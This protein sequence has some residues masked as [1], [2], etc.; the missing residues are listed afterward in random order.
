MPYDDIYNPDD[1][2]NPY[3]EATLSITNLYSDKEVMLIN[4]FAFPFSFSS[5][6]RTIYQ[7]MVNECFLNPEK[8]VKWIPSVRRCWIQWMDGSKVAAINRMTPEWDEMIHEY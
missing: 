8:Y 5:R 1:S 7:Q 4:E 3:K 2:R 6:P